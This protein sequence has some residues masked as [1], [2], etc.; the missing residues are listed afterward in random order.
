[1]SRFVASLLLPIF[2]LIT[3]CNKKK[4]TQHA[5]VSAELRSTGV[6][7]LNLSQPLNLVDDSIAPAPI[8]ATIESYKVPVGSINLV[9]SNGSGYS[10]ASH[11]FYS[12][13][14]ATDKECAVD[15][16]DS[17]ALQNLLNGSNK[18]SI[19]VDDDAVAYD[20]V[21]VGSCHEHK[22]DDAASNY[23]S[24][25]LK[26]SFVKGGV[27]Y[28]TNA[29]SKLSTTGPAEEIEMKSVYGGCGIQSILSQPVTLGPDSNVGLVLYADP[30]LA[31]YGVTGVADGNKDTCVN[32][33]TVALCTDLVAISGT[34]DTKAPTVERYLLTIPDRSDVVMTFLFD[35]SDAPFGASGRGLFNGTEENPSFGQPSYGLKKA[36]DGTYTIVGE[37][38]SNPSTIISGF[39]REAHSGTATPTGETLT[40][41]ATKL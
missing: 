36:A 26:A 31:V 7:T 1:M 33:G 21:A 41:T 16:T 19:E 32:N 34:V 8:S 23:F 6:K 11:D 25:W 38:G 24:I 14:A 2:C 35:S 10:V 3:A 20:A 29:T 9:V 28:Y 13:P 4:D 12:C 40:Y 5:D 18:N 27:T 17:S 22:S 37:G 30:T 15:L 39:K